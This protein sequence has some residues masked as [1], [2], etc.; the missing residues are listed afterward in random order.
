MRYTS[1]LQ[2]RRRLTQLGD[3]L[4][5]IH[6]C[7]PKPLF[8]TEVTLTEDHAA[9]YSGCKVPECAASVLQTS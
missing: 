7:D 1:S 8:A 3:N 6:I 2:L 9:N 4:I 5:P